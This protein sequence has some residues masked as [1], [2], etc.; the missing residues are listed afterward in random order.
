MIVWSA[1]LAATQS[2]STYSPPTA[3]AIDN[4]GKILVGGGGQ[5]FV[6]EKD[7]ITG[8]AQWTPFKSHS[9]MNTVSEF[10]LPSQLNREVIYK[11]GFMRPFVGSLAFFRPE[12]ALNVYWNG[13]GFYSV[14]EGVY[15]EAPLSFMKCLPTTMGLVGHIHIP[16]DTVQDLLITREQREINKPDQMYPIMSTPYLVASPKDPTKK[17][18][19]GSLRPAG[20]MPPQQVWENAWDF[21][22]FVVEDVYTIPHKTYAE[23][24]LTARTRIRGMAFNCPQVR[25]V[26]PELIVTEAYGDEIRESVPPDTSIV[27]VDPT[28]VFTGATAERT[29][30]QARNYSDPSSTK[31][32]S[33]GR[34]IAHQIDP[35]GS[36]TSLVVE[37]GRGR[38]RVVEEGVL[39][40][41]DDDI[42][43]VTDYNRKMQLNLRRISQTDAPHSDKIEAVRAYKEDAAQCSSDAV[44]AKTNVNKSRTVFTAK[45]LASFSDVNDPKYG[46]N[47][48]TDALA[49]FMDPANPILGYAN[50]GMPRNLMKFSSSIGREAIPANSIVSFESGYI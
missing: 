44:R 2:P 17:Y 22:V 33:S 42:V 12:K 47:P 49:A 32:T 36:L 21:A 11:G 24:L 50:G 19:P 46:K 8:I 34:V 10:K 39:W 27:I 31:A 1:P 30:R 38:T 28:E 48:A 41:V 15:V 18:Y 9:E 25:V 13:G 3:P 35:T 7:R 45:Y 14:N 6:S 23:R 5:L 20:D 29:T 16:L 4:V 43:S 26:E 40:V 37:D